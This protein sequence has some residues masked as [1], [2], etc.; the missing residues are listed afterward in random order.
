M[1]EVAARREK[2]AQVLVF[3]A[4]KGLNDL[5]NLKM[6]KLVYFADKR[7]LLKYGR[8][9]TGDRYFGMEHGPVPSRIYDGLR[10][11][12]FGDVL[13]C[14]GPGC[15]RYP[16]WRAKAGVADT[17]WLSE[18]DEEVLREVF[19]ELGRRTGR[20]LRD[21]AHEQSDV[22][23]A[24]AALTAKGAPGS[25]LIPT[26]DMLLDL[27]P[28]DQAAMSAILKEESENDYLC[29]RFA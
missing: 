6:A 26:E 15:G 20:E 24:D 28:E 14:D 18:S 19:G 27:P 13:D 1:K 7:H 9:I 22:R 8:T 11:G 16:V 21:L 3:F 29:S 17:Q 4:S 23:K 2:L 12:A 10:F 25:I 5:T